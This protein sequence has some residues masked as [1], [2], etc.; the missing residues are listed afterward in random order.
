M[1]IVVAVAGDDCSENADRE[2][3]PLDFDPD[4]CDQLEEDAL[5]DPREVARSLLQLSQGI[6]HLEVALVYGGSGDSS[7]ELPPR[8]AAFVDELGGRGHL[9]DA[10]SLEQ[11]EL[12]PG[13]VGALSGALAYRSV[14]IDESSDS[15]SQCEVFARMRQN[16]EV[17]EVVSIQSEYLSM[18]LSAESVCP[19]V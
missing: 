3:P 11:A 8:L 4:R 18:S 17:K 14:C 9:F 12:A 7:G 19:K 16:D 13:R 10:S 6:I 5:L 2:G 1:F 15:P